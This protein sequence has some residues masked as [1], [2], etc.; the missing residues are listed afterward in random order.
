[1]RGSNTK[2]CRNLMI[3]MT[4]G[5]LWHGASWTFVVWGVLHGLFL[6]LHRGFQAFCKRRPRLDGLLQ[7]IPGTTL[8]VVLT[9]LCVCLG[10]VF[11]R[12]VTFGDAAEILHRLVVPH[13]GLSAPLH[14]RSLWYTV[15]VVALCHALAQRG[16]WKKVSARLPAPVVGFGYAL[17]LTVA[18][19]LA[20]D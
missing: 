8:R 2:T 1:S 12:A 11:L 14:N 15:A 17:V 6:V 20:P 4:L 9:F 3:T 5:G 13:D 16:H 10:W 19:V 7:S 18:L